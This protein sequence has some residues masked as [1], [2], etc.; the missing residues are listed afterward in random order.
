M[1]SVM[2]LLPLAWLALG[3]L[4]MMIAFTDK[5]E[6]AGEREP[7]RPRALPNPTEHPLGHVH[8]A[9]VTSKMERRR[10]RVRLERAA[11]DAAQADGDP[12]D[13]QAPRRAPR[14][15]RHGGHHLKRVV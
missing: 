11:A 6:P 4:F 7:A 13:G 15:R 8:L 9:L 1:F 5:D 12:G 3:V 10:E 2:L 14:P